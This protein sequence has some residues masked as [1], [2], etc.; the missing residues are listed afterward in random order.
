MRPILTR[1]ELRAFDRRAVELGVP[2]LSLMENAGRGACDVILRLAA[3]PSTRFVIVCGEGNNGGDG[4]VVARHL[5]VR[6]RRAQVL[7]HGVVARLSADARVNHDAFVGVGGEV[8]VAPTAEAC[9]TALAHADVVVD[10]LFGTGLSRPL[11]REARALVDAMN[12]ARGLKIAIDLPSGLDADT[13]QVLGVAFSADHTVKLAHRCPGL[14]TAGGRLAAGV[15]HDADIGVPPTLPGGPAPRAWLVESSDVASWLAQR[16][17]ADNKYTAGSVAVVGGSPGKT[18]AALL[19][20]DAALAAGAG[21]STIVTWLACA[22]SLEARV[23][24]VMLSTLDPSRLGE[25]LVQALEKKRAVAVGPGL[26]LGPDAALVVDKIVAGWDGPK[27]LD[28]DAITAFAGRASAL[29]HARGAVV[30]LPHAGELARLLGTSSGEIEADRFGWARRAARETGAVV[31]LK[32]A[33]T[34]VAERDEV[35]VSET[36]TPALATA[37]SGDVLAGIVA[38]L[39][40]ALPPLRAAVAAAHLHGLAAEAWRDAHAGAERGL[41]AGEL[42]AHL[43]DVIARLLEGRRRPLTA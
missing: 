29:Q 42:S 3:S 27:V 8:L 7:L 21:L 19:A 4:F 24:E 28:A 26:G 10:A 11:A 14:A 33:S 2:S 41:R 12:A 32:G 13:G 43:P 9:S 6:G 38:A 35:W 22:P 18:G 31:L 1:A 40:V 39:S 34:V 20:A 5:A 16:G 17:P 15:V 23:R 36:G 37:G 25:S 30:L